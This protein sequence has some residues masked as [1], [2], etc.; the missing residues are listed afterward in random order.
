MAVTAIT[1]PSAWGNARDL[2]NFGA[3]VYVKPCGAI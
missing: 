3:A 2:R 1:I